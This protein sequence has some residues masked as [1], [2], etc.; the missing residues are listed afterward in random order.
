MT[1]GILK[2]VVIISL[3]AVPVVALIHRIHLPSIIGF[4]LTGLMIGPFGLGWI[5]QS[6]EIELLAEMGVALLLF[7]VGL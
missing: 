3:V 1:E 2:D 5:H 6:N 7:S 4:L